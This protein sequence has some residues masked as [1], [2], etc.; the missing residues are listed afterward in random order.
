M[1][2]EYWG[3]KET[4][5]AC[6]LGS[7]FVYTN[8]EWERASN[9]L[10]FS[11]SQNRPQICIQGPKGSGKTTVIACAQ[12][13]LLQTETAFL[14][15]PWN[16]LVNQNRVDALCALLEVELPEEATLMTALVEKNKRGQRV[17]LVLPDTGNWKKETLQDLTDWFHQSGLHYSILFCHDEPLD[18]KLDESAVRIRMPSLT[19]EEVSAFLLSR[20]HVGG[21][22]GAK[23]MFTPDALTALHKHSGGYPGSVLDLAQRALMISAQRR[24]FMVDAFLMELAVQRGGVMAA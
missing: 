19:L 9:Q 5:F 24:E 20:F 11:I 10:V 22:P 1:V 18:L 6:E 3:I 13:E 17:V 8:R 4:A 21:Y 15:L 16:A 23:L 2:E 12:K 14:K 7:Q